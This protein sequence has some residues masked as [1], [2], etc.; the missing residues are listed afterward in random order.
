[1]SLPFIYDRRPSRS[2]SRI[3]VGVTQRGKVRVV[4]PKLLPK[5][6]LEQF[7]ASKAD[8][9]LAELQKQASKTKPQ[10]SA[11]LIPELISV[12]G[13]NLPLKITQNLQSPPKITLTKQYVAI[14]T[15][16]NPDLKTHQQ[17]LAT[18]LNQQLH[19]LAENYLLTRTKTLATQMETTYA[20]VTLRAQQTRWGSC[21]S[22]GNLNFNWKL[23]NFP[24]AI[25]DY[26]IIHELAHRTHLNHSQ[27]FWTLVAKFD[28]AHAQHRGWLKRHGAVALD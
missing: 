28:P 24:P 2:F 6:L 25:I 22:Q 19:R 13:Q 15:W 11:S 21:S 7:L 9:I 1:M 10:V 12:F 5:F 23:V 18:Q 17:K 27:A 14:N 4:A 26:V 8:W 16:Q 3:S 20:R